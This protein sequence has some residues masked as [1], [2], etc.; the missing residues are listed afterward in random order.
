MIVVFLR[1]KKISPQEFVDLFFALSIIVGFV[2]GG[3]IR[4]I[5]NTIITLLKSEFRE[6]RVI[7]GR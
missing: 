3:G 2:T 5:R 6:S 1:H 7:I 4:L